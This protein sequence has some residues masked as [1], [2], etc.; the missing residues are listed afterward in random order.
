MLAVDSSAWIEW[1]IDGPLTAELAQKMPA[2]S[3]FLVPTIVQHE[4]TKWLLRERGEEAA[5]E[6]IAYTQ[7]C[8]VAVLDTATAIDAANLSRQYKLATADAVIYAAA[9]RHGAGLLTC[10]AHF[11]NLPGVTFIAKNRA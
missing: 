7:K 3:D 5:D 8:V 6:F 11:E 10:D 4:L 2:K 9:L 1:L